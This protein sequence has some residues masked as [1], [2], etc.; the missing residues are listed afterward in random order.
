[1]SHRLEALKR[2]LEQDP[3]NELARYG[4]AMEYARAGEWEQAAEH[5]EA[6]LEVNPDYAAAYFQL[7]Q[8]LEKL[9]RIEQ[10]RQTYRLGI[11][12]H[13]RQGNQQ[14]RRE[15]ERALQLLG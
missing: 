13:E 10:A 3:A 2:L 12:V 15:L 14:A 1:M 7:G 5:L 11:Q 9:G 4:L 8:V 6:L